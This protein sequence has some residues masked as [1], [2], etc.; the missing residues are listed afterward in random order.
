MR[1]AAGAV[2]SQSDVQSYLVWFMVHMT[3]SVQTRPGSC[4]EYHSNVD[5]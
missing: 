2:A 4:L 3:M 5:T 1:W